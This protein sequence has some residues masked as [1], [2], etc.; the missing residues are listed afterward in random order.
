M[1][2]QSNN[3][4][5]ITN[6]SY[7]LRMLH[8]ETAR[9]QH[10][11]KTNFRGE[12]IWEEYNPTHFL[13]I[14]FCFN[15]LYSVDWQTSLERGR[16]RNHGRRLT[17]RDKYKLMLDFCFDDK[18][19]YKSFKDKFIRIVTN[20]LPQDEIFNIFETIHPDSHYLGNIQRGDIIN[21]KSA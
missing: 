15:T 7:N 16:I 21:F 5:S 19:Y 6:N 14:F 10:A 20:E 2:Y 9:L 17:E 4:R 13:Y 18:Q 3:I 8:I 12:S 11:I 1:E